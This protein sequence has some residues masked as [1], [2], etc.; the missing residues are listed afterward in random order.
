MIY[1]TLVHL[2]T[3]VKVTG[4]C[5]VMGERTLVQGQGQQLDLQGQGQGQGL[6][7]LCMFVRGHYSQ[8]RA[9]PAT[10][11][12]SVYLFFQTS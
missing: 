7:S 11:L 1:D 12:Y 3:K 10:L 5:S 6:T 9:V 2:D 8:G 4:V